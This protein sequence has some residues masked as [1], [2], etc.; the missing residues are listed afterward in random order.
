MT[1]IAAYILR[2][3]IARAGAL[4]R[5]EQGGALE[6]VLVTAAFALPIMGLGRFLQEMLSDFF[7][8]IAFCVGWPFL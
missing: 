1:R 3:A 4:H 5:D 7:S 6:Y 8:M 2:R